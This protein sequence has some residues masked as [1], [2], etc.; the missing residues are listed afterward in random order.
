MPLNVDKITTGSLSINNNELFISR[1]TVLTTLGEFMINPKII[2]SGT[3]DETILY[4]LLI[5]KNTFR[6]GDFVSGIF[7]AI[8][9][10]IETNNGDATLNVYYNTTDD[11]N[12]STFI[13]NQTFDSQTN[14]AFSYSTIKSGLKF[15]SN[16]ETIENDNGII[17]EYSTNTLF[18]ITKDNY[19]I[20][21]VQFVDTSDVI[22]INKCYSRP[23]IT[24]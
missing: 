4:S 17:T 21:T 3:T 12:G 2:V 24:R 11:L 8:E 16:T 1:P 10:G 13:E 20:F 7:A 19:F 18:D 14:S 5:P 23:Q 15:I 9:F 22:A 6:V